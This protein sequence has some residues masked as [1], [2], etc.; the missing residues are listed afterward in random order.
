MASVS[1]SVRSASVAEALLVLPVELGWVYMVVVG[2]VGSVE[3]RCTVAV[4]LGVVEQ[5][6][7][8]LAVE[9]EVEEM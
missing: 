4:V 5:R 7:L 3:E 2:E 6:T 1:V 8:E 9:A